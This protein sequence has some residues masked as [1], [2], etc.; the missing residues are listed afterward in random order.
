LHKAVKSRV[1][2]DAK[3]GPT[4]RSLIKM[5][6]LGGDATPFS[7]NVVSAATY[8]EG[9]VWQA[10]GSHPPAAKQPGYGS[11]SLPVQIGRAVP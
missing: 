1:M 4:A 6:Y 11:W 9:L 10:I 2:N 3:L 7:A 5:W 8:K